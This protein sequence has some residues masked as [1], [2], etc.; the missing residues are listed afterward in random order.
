MRAYSLVSADGHVCE[1]PT[2][3]TDRFPANLR[4]RAPRLESF[5]EGDAWVFEGW[6]GP[7]NFGH[8]SAAG[9]PPDQI[10][11]WCRWEDVPDRTWNPSE[12]VK[13]Q[14]LDGVDAELLYS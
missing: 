9:R 3:W 14:D 11:A 6:N 8:T 5:P 4:S 1:P 10:N 13:A 7:I 12:R 2:I